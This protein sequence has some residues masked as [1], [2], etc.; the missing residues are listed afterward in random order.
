MT[1]AAW[2]AAAE[3]AADVAGA[4]IRPFFRAAHGI[5]AAL[6]EDRSPVTIADRTA[7][8]AMRAVLAERCPDHGILGEEFGLQRPEARLRWVL[9][10]IDGTRAFIT[11][12]PIFGTLVALLEG[13]RPILGVIDQPVT[14]ER[15]VGVADQP[16]RFRGPFGGRPG[17]RACPDL[18][19]A[20]LSC[21]SPAMLNAEE[22]PRWR[23]LA[24]RVGRVSWGGDCYA[25]GLLAL[26]QLDIVAESEMKPWDW[27]AIVPV[28]EGAGGR[29]TDWQGRP[30]RADGP[31]QVLAVGDPA[32]LDQAVALLR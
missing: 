2:I 14:G 11:G 6:K 10:P 13:D 29:V 20:E 15:W 30:L 3:A 24:D 18:G 22:T 9:D 4:V 8:L 7:E 31:G 16:T 28:V 12:R 27:A 5:D 21:T 19:A 23:R 32:L 17:C 25:Y 1:E 26:G